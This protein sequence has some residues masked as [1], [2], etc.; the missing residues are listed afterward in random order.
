MRQFFLWAA[1]CAALALAVPAAAQ[2]DQTL[3][4][5]P[6]MGWNS[7]NH[8]GC[9]IDEKLIEATA[10][11]LVSS[12]LRDAGYTYVTLDDCWHGARDGDG[13]IQPDPVRF[14]SGMKALGDY[15]H[16]RGLK[17]GIYSDAGEKTCAGRPGSQGHEFQDA[18]QYAR[19]G[20]DYL[21]YD[22]CNTGS[23]AAQRN[24]REAYATMSRAI[25]AS[26]RPMVL[27]ICE[28][29][30]NQPWL[31]GKDAGHL[32]RTTGDITNCWDCVVHHG[33]WKSSGILPILD[34]Q[35]DIRGHSGPSG[36][37]DPDMMEV[38]NLATDKE[39]RSHF[40]MWAMLSAPLIIGTDVPGMREEVRK[41]LANPR[42]VAIDQ[43]ALGIS[44]MR[45]LTMP[46]LE[47]WAK[48]LADGEWAIAALNRGEA[49]RDYRLNWSEYQLED[50]LNSR[51]A[52]FAR[53]TYAIG[54]SWDGKEVG[55]TAEP[56][57]IHL[58]PHDTLV[59]RLVPKTQ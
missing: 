26:G 55:T 42:I 20:V 31:W 5:T 10:D 34:Q 39:N 50:N 13:N 29:G 4:L 27:S 33:N 53:E 16:T 15:L 47:I 58:E 3:A 45:W 48:P 22:W 7:W 54:D 14:P 9:N 37:N 28:W 38:G 52:D 21:K 44:A 24:P 25:A 43:D 36:W 2:K 40:A 51:R 11:A 6:P 12:G 17:F 41:I 49:P 8:Y 59:F 35:M 57:E 23:G 30:E 1:G 56:L 46:G 18:A 19:W 32:W